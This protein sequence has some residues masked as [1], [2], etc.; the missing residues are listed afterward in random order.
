[1]YLILSIIA[2]LFSLQPKPYPWCLKYEVNDKEYANPHLNYIVV[3]EDS[4]ISIH[5]DP[6]NKESIV[7]YTFSITDNVVGIRTINH[8]NRM[9]FS[10]EI[11]LEEYMESTQHCKLNY[12]VDSLK[13]DFI[14]S[15]FAIIITALLSDS[16]PNVFPQ[17]LFYEQI[18]N[19]PIKVVSGTRITQ[20]VEYNTDQSSI[21][22]VLR[23]IN[24]RGYQIME[25]HE[26]KI[27]FLE[28]TGYTYDQ[29]KEILLKSKQE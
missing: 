23:Y 13:V 16:I 7:S 6:S 1:M 3:Y 18:K 14:D 27:K 8:R 4:I 9:F 25:M 19:S 5:V 28:K 12:S 21:N 29:M 11:P 20:L 24:K 10:H 17:M 15:T 26:F 22:G 2:I